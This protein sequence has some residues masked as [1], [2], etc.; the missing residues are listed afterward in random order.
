MKTLT[1][2]IFL[3]V[4]LAHTASLLPAQDF[5]QQLTPIPGSS[6]KVQCLATNSKG[7]I[8]AGVTSYPSSGVFRSVDGG[9]IWEQVLSIDY[10]PLHLEINVDDVIYMGGQVSFL[11]VSEDGGD[12]WRK[13]YPSTFSISMLYCHG[14]D[15]LYA[16]GWDNEGILF[17]RSY[18]KGI[19]WDRM[20]LKPDG[21]IT[22]ESIR[23]LVV[24]SEG[25]LY[26]AV[27]GYE[28]GIFDGGLYRSF[29]QGDSWER[30]DPEL[31]FVT[32]IAINSHNDIFIASYSHGFCVLRSGAVSVEILIAYETYDVVVDH[33]DYIY[34]SLY[35]KKMRSFDHGITFEQ[36]PY[37]GITNFYPSKD[38]FLYA[39]HT[40]F[41]GVYRSTLPILSIKEQVQISSN[42]KFFPN[43]V[44]EQLFVHLSDLKQQG[45]I[46][47]YSLLGEKVFEQQAIA[48]TIETINVDSFPKGIYILKIE[49][50]D[51]VFSSKFI[52]N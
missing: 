12:S 52:K 27:I 49:T 46:V 24:T 10:M 33:A 47:I 14:Q 30:V 13:I 45:V 44:H 32:K 41:N 51:E 26:A 18:D 3:L 19:S 42:F 22:S 35:G 31:S 34:T 38:G 17:L 4:L 9:Q 8:F 36:I 11:M 40:D 7:H 5:W 25:V 39:F 15:T 1:K 16:G 50:S 20:Y 28:P 48:K 2:Y 23:D 21:F 29:D 43:P 6:T 37:L